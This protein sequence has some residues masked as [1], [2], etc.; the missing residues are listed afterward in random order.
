MAGKNKVGDTIKRG[1][2]NQIPTKYNMLK[3]LTF[4]ILICN[5]IYAARG[6]YFIIEDPSILQLLNSYEHQLSREEKTRFTP[7]MPVRILNKDQILSDNYT[8]AIKVLFEDQLYFIVKKHQGSLENILPTDIFRM[9]EN[10]QI[11]GDTVRITESDKILLESGPHKLQLLENELIVRI[12]EYKNKIYVKRL[13]QPISFGWI[14]R[15]KKKYWRKYLPTKLTVNDRQ[16]PVYLIHS[17]QAHIDEYN[18]LLKQLF[19]FFYQLTNQNLK[20]PA[21][22]VYITGDQIHCKLENKPAGNNF[23]KSTRLLMQ[24]IARVLPQQL[25]R[26][27]QHDD[28]IIIT[29]GKK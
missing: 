17:I 29:Y 3:L 9:F 22:K 27:E 2:I 21:W 23:D 25:G 10:V 13:T 6:D 19:V 7:F 1:L 5:L 11:I 12:F 16:F 28:T 18:K 26:I 4:I 24:R 20:T 14:N 8:K 15:H